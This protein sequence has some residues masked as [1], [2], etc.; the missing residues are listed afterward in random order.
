MSAEP[1]QEW[2]EPDGDPREA[3]GR[4]AR[5]LK[6]G[7]ALYLG[8]GVGVEAT[9]K[10]QG[11]ITTE[12]YSLTPGGKSFDG[13]LSA[14]T[15]ALLEAGKKTS[16]DTPGGTTAVTDP[17]I[18]A[19][20]F[21]LDSS[22]R[23]ERA[24]VR[25]Y[26]ARIEARAKA[27]VSVAG[28]GRAMLDDDGWETRR[29]QEAEAN[30][31][32]IAAERKRLLSG[33][34]QE[35]V[36]PAGGLL[37]ALR[38]A[39]AGKPGTNW[40]QVTP[41]ARKQLGGILAHYRK[42]AR[43]FTAC[44]RDNRKRFG[45]RA[46]RVCAVVKDLNERSTKWR[47]G[48]KKKLSELSDDELGALI[49]ES[50]QRVA[51]LDDVLGRGAAVVLALS[52]GLADDVAELGEMALH[53]LS[54]LLLAGHEG[55]EELAEAHELQ[56]RHRTGQWS[57]LLARVG[58]TDGSPVI[59]PDGE[60]RLNTPHPEPPVAEG[61]VG[62]AQQAS[63]P[64]CP[65]C[66]H[67]QANAGTCEVCG[68][69]LA[70][71]TAVVIPPDV[72]LGEGIV[73]FAQ[74]QWREALH[75]RGRGG[76]FSSKG[77]RTI[78][79]GPFAGLERSSLST[80]GGRAPRRPRGDQ[81]KTAS[82]DAQ[83][84][85]RDRIGAGDAERA[86]AQRRA[87]GQEPQQNRQAAK[88]AKL[89]EEELAKSVG[90]GAWSGAVDDAVKQMRESGTDSEN[91][92]R[93]KLPNG[94]LGP[95]GPERVALHARMVSLLFQGADVH[96]NPEALFTAGGGGSGKSALLKA[97]LVKVPKNAV[98]INPDIVKTMFPEWEKLLATGDLRG[99]ALMHEESSHVA[100]MAMNLAML[101]RHHVVVD[102]TGNG[103]PGSYAK[104]IKAAQAAGM[105]AEIIYAHVRTEEAVRRAIARGKKTGR[106]VPE[107]ALR[108]AH[109]SV[110][111][112]YM[113]DVAGLG[114]PIRIY[115]TSTRQPVLIAEHPDGGAVKVHNARLF[116]EFKQKAVTG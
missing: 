31:A 56:H 97:G 72:A 33:K 5:R 69:A 107:G 3:L 11:Q 82:P 115:D 8:G 39:E 20:L 90:K 43:P 7:G 38:E 59:G 111:A 19:R 48:G 32:A 22:E 36:A 77:G 4:L 102:G 16:P 41:K 112:R 75:P 63:V 92:Y 47:K 21:E 52:E 84:R 87:R 68:Q 10:V 54:L 15:A 106:M 110:S 50:A 80:A 78:T 116:E 30:L 103:G 89:S 66:G 99:A 44:V 108:A 28:F 96:A 113:A 1:L 46:E 37:G 74:K 105:D 23:E 17:A 13:P 91:I 95:Y 45:D 42:M 35:A 67:A 79:Q 85:A 65:A 100:K 70:A 6:G 12:T 101:R 73:G 27:P 71:P 86:D 25:R 40:K 109:Q 81:P 49:V 9:K 57:K 2:Y 51:A 94:E 18:A 55:G 64:R 53:D 61:Y 114:V 104:K 93:L 83:R 29:V 14:V 24:T 88:G 76:Q 62:R 58:S 98:D 34:V 60:L 26:K